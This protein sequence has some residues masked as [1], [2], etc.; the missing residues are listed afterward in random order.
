MR[1]APDSRRLCRL[2]V[3]KAPSHRP[4]V[5]KWTQC[6]QTC[7][8]AKRP[9]ARH[10][11]QLT[12]VKTGTILCAINVPQRIHC[13][14]VI[15]F[16]CAG[17]SAQVERLQLK[18]KI[19]ETASASC[20]DEA[21]G[22]LL[23]SQLVRT[24]LFISPGSRYSAY[25]EGEAVASK[26]NTSSDSMCFNTSRLFVAGK[27][28]K[29]RQVLVVEPSSQALGNSISIVDWSPDGRTL[30]FA[31]SV[32]QWGSEAGESFVRLFDADSGT[33]SDPQFIPQA[34]CKRAGKS[35]AAVIEPLGFS[36]EGQ[37]ILQASPFFM[38]GEEKAEEDSCV[39]KKGLWLLDP[40]TQTLV[41]LP[42]DYRMDR[43]GEFTKVRGN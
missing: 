42:D 17:T 9:P 33:L 7:N 6:V 38:L 16:C 14:V 40:A 27:D 4:R 31:Q 8:L 25:A 11:R 30:L 26:S 10:S 37:V 1:P 20:Y 39:Q 35:C 24:P 34:F 21:T 32:F 12:A 23:G 18:A 43:Y 22:K 13:L 36:S 19:S 3:P 15:L 29:F 5:P 41:L 2:S 28:Q